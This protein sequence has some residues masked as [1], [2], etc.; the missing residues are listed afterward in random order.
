MIFGRDYFVRR[1]SR[2]TLTHVRKRF[3][4]YREGLASKLD[5]DEP[6]NWLLFLN[7][8]DDFEAH[9]KD[10]AEL[11]GREYR[12]DVWAAAKRDDGEIFNQIINR[13]RS[14]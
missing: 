11:K 10:E 3:Q 4:Q 12:W 6:T 2:Y 7:Y 13:F 5:C 9:Q 1:R 14:G 8:L